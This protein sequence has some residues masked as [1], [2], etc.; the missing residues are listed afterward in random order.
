MAET[1]VRPRTYFW[2]YLALLALTLSTTLFGY[3]NLGWFSMVLALAFALAKATLI[4]TFFMHALY[5]KILIRLII[6]G[7]LLWFLILVTLTMCD[8]ITRS[9]FPK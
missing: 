6:G 4:A 3:L 8:Y 9:W 5:E 7:S 1:I 2:T